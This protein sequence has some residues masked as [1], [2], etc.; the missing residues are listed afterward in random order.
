LEAV[1]V[2]DCVHP[3]VCYKAMK[4]GA[5]AI[6]RGCCVIQDLLWLTNGVSTGTQGEGERPPLEAVTVGDWESLEK[7]T[8]CC[9]ELCR[10]LKLAIALQLHVVTTYRCSINRIT[11][12]NPGE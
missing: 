2:G 7:L 3:A 11:N 8:A 1:T 10:V 5:A 4:R 12:S 6:T 9:S